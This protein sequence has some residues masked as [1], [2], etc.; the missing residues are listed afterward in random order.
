MAGTAGGLVTANTYRNLFRRHATTFVPPSL[1]FDR[2]EPGAGERSIMNE[3]TDSLRALL[4]DLTQVAAAPLAQQAVY[5]LFLKL[6]DG[7]PPADLGGN[8]RRGQAARPGMDR[9]DYTV[10]VT[11]DTPMLNAPKPVRLDVALRVWSAVFPWER[12]RGLSRCPKRLL[13]EGVDESGKMIPQF[14][15]VSFDANVDFDAPQEDETSATRVVADAR[16]IRFVFEVCAWLPAFGFLA[17]LLPR[18]R[19]MLALG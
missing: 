16:G 13:E 15:S 5:P 6:H 1:R 3:S 9:Q 7:P 11:R 17:V 10:G 8:V 19:E 14:E 2:T 18:R 12:A 4:A